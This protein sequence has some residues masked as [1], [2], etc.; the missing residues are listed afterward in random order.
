MSFVLFGFGLDRR[1]RM[2]RLRLSIGS[3]IGL[4]NGGFGVPLKEAFCLSTLIS[5]LIGTGDRLIGG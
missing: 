2:W 1:M 3:G 5:L 4:E